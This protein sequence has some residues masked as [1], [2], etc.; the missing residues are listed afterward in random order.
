MA[1]TKYYSSN[2]NIKPRSSKSITAIIIHYT[3][4]QSERESLK[5]LISPKSK[6]SC[7]YLINR[8]GIVFSLVKEK[9]IAWHAGKS[10]WGKY[11]N[12][13]KNSIGIELVNKG[14]KYGYQAFTKIQIKKL[15]QLCKNLK[16]KYKIKNKLILGHSDIAP[17]RKID[18][19]EKFPWHFLSSKGIGIYPMRKKQNKKPQKNNDIRVFFS[20]L[21]KVGYRYLKKK[22]KRKIIK[23][24]QRRFRQR[25][26][27]GVLD[28]ET[29]IISEIL[30]KKSNIS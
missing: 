28:S 5:K 15:V 19:G 30:A 9:N 10:M 18:P 3:G 7:H 13:N 16:R 20:N 29:L 24:F 6:V 8:R 25:K 26:V 23:N 27:D 21:D 1:I 22:F 4:M 14:H 11:K 17:L 12:L 2:F